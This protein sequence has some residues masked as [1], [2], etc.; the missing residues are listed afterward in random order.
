METQCRNNNV[1]IHQ[2]Q[3]RSRFEEPIGGREGHEMDV[4]TRTPTPIQTDDI[5][6]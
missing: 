4:E 5:Y 2:I 6:R 3:L 1:D